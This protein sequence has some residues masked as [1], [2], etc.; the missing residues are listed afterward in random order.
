MP[1]LDSLLGAVN[2]FGIPPG[3]HGNVVVIPGILGSRPHRDRGRAPDNVWPLPPKIDRLLLDADGQREAQPGR[4]VQATRINHIYLPLLAG[5]DTA[6]G[7]LHR[8]FLR[9]AEKH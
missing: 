7:M 4:V 6:A 1:V 9:L 8:V 3:N 5:L 2:E